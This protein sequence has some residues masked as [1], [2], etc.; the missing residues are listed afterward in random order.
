MA[1]AKIRRTEIGLF[2]LLLLSAMYFRHPVDYDNTQSRFFLLSASVD[3][4]RLDIEMYKNGTIDIS[5]AGD[6]TYSNKAIGAPIVAAPVYWVLR[7]LT[8]IRSDAPLSPR[9]RTICTWVTTTLPYAFL[10]VVLFRV[11]LAMGV[12]PWS[13]F[14]AVLAYAFGSIAWIHAT[15]FSGHQMAATFSFFSFASVFFLSQSK[16]PS[17]GACWFGAGLLAGLAALA[18][19]TAISIAGLLSVYA[20][21]K[22]KRV[23]QSMSFLA[24]CAVSAVALLAYNQHCFG[25]PLSF[26]YAHLGH[27]EF[28]EGS[29]QG[30]LGIAWPNPAAFLSLLVSPARGVLF[31]MPVF[32]LSIPGF[33]IWLGQSPR[34]PEWAVSGLIIL[35]YLLIVSGFYGWHGGWTFGPRYL[36]PMLPFL[37]IPMALGMDRRWFAPLFAASFLQIGFAQVA[38][39]HTPE[40]IRNPLVEC[41]Y[42]L[43]RYG[44]M[45]DNLGLRLGLRSLYSVMPLL[46]AAI[47]ILRAV[48]PDRETFPATA[49]PEDDSIPAA[50]RPVYLM[51][52]LAIAACLL[53]VRSPSAAD[54]HVYNANLLA[55][56]AS[57]LNSD[58]LARAALEEENSAKAMAGR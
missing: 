31:I 46:I 55:H 25:S 36:A 3:Y 28:A 14:C 49:P 18:D 22:S 50:W 45:A 57:K 29:R 7:K 1:D 17:R 35:S 26:S 27:G 15:L 10:G 56:A 24:G 40:D 34:R 5:V 38:M 20:V 2:L 47:L 39:P 12:E 8:P 16:I 41:V 48:W 52:L 54:V 19:Y 4:G 51:M 21:W 32:L 11:I 58:P 43:F 53:V 33:W 9:A 6:R 13:A 23:G 44:Y 30:I 42:P 37:V